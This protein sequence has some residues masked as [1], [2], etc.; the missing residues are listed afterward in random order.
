M[1]V[2][3]GVTSLQLLI[4]LFFED[5]SM[6]KSNASKEYQTNCDIVTSGH[7]QIKSQPSYGAFLEGTGLNSI[8]VE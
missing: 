5:I 6:V 2:Y 8:K 7:A 3:V 1:L 4:L